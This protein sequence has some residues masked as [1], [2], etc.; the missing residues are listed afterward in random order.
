M[1]LPYLALL[2]LPVLY[3]AAS[4][5]FL[6]VTEAWHNPGSGTWRI[7]LARDRDTA[8]TLTLRAGR[9]TLAVW[10]RDTDRN[11]LVDWAPMQDLQVTFSGGLTRSGARFRFRIV[12]GHQPIHCN[13]PQFKNFS[14]IGSQADRLR[15]E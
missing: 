8:G 6:D 14:L 1:R 10:T 4:H 7:Q 12:D 5:P 9:G 2:F 11:L 13:D 3:L 15:Q